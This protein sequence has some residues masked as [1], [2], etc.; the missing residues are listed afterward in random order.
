MA[1][2]THIFDELIG[3]YPALSPLRGELLQA[4]R[5]LASC[6]R[7]GGKLL[8]AGNGGS[9]ADAAHIV[10]ELMK[11]FHHPRPLP[12]SMREA[13][14]DDEAGAYLAANLQGALPAI[15]L[16]GHIAL[17][18]AYA[19]DRA[20]DLAM[21]QEVYGYARPGDV[22]LAISTSG[23]SR[24]VLYAARTA[25]ACGMRVLALTG[26]SGGALRALSDLTLAVPE[27]DTYRVQELHLPI[28]HALCLALEEELFGGEA[29]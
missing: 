4:H 16:T 29:G 24:N 3:R 17:E 12:D 9:A 22:L 11:D 14:G 26:E 21:A 7:A 2:V 20:P 10:G 18:S 23:H 27:R 19:N 28:Y 5:L 8:I 25:R 13:L 1:S 6:F 15:A